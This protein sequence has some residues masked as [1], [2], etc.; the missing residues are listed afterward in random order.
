L[1]CIFTSCD[2]KTES[3]SGN[4][5]KAQKNMA[6]SDAISKAFETGDISKID[7]AATT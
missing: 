2:S 7:S 6:A 1:I 5:D 3:T 4:N